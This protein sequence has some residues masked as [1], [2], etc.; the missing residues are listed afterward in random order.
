M[1]E[2]DTSVQTPCSSLA[3]ALRF[4]IPLPY[5]L[6]CHH[7]SIFRYSVRNQLLKLVTLTTMNETVS[8]QRHQVKRFK[9]CVGSLCIV[10]SGAQSI[11][12][13]PR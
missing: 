12:N 7:Y 3:Q 10:P 5:V 4:G 1:G 9:H 13:G 8:S 2:I 11:E 6:T